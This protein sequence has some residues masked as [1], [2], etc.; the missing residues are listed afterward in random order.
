M[1]NTEH[2][3]QQ[4]EIAY[5]SSLFHVFEYQDID[6]LNLY[7]ED[8]EAEENYCA[9]AGIKEVIDLIKLL[10]EVVRAEVKRGN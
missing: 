5:K 2:C 6:G 1:L 3:N 4:K 9:C 7:L 8:M 10:K